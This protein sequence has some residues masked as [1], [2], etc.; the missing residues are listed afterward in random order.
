[1]AGVERSEPP[2]NGATGGSLRSSHPRSKLETTD[3]VSPDAWQKIDGSRAFTF[4]L[5]ES[6]V[7]KTALSYIGPYRL[8]TLVHDGEGSRIWKAHQDGSQQ[9]VG[10]KI[11]TDKYARSRERI[12]SSGESTPSGP[13]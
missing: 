9:F 10:I 4:L 6:P 3:F 5:T 13:G 7:T 2:E 11:L 1:M 12:G 8:L